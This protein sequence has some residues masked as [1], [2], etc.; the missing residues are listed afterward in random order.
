VHLHG[1]EGG[2]RG[3]SIREGQEICA[4]VQEGCEAKDREGEGRGRE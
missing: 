2:D 1:K 3:S 4:E